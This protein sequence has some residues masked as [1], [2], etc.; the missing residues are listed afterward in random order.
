MIAGQNH[1]ACRTYE[2][3]NA[4]HKARAPVKDFVYSTCRMVHSLLLMGNFTKALSILGN[5]FP[6]IR[7]VLKLE[8]HILGAAMLAQLRRSLHRYDL[9]FPMSRVGYTDVLPGTIEKLQRTTCSNSALFGI[10]VIRRWSSRSTYW[11]LTS[12]SASTN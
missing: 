1:L 3:S 9:K 6:T 8:Q 11:R 12:T 7:G 5:L 2:V 10:L 4:V